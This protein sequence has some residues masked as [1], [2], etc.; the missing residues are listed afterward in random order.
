[1]NT[2][3]RSLV[4][5]FLTLLFAIL[6]AS[7]V[8]VADIVSVEFEDMPK[9]TYLIGEAYEPFTVIV[10]VGEEEPYTLSS[11]DGNVEVTGFNSDTVG[12]RTM[13]I[14]ITDLEDA[15]VNFVYTVV[16]SM[17]DTL[18]AGGS[19]TLEDPY[20]IE[21]AQ[22]LSNVRLALDQN[23]ILNNDIDLS[24]IEWAPIGSVSILT[25]GPQAISISIN[26]GFSGTFDGNDYTIS[27][28]YSRNESTSLP[29]ALFVAVYGAD[30]N[31]K[32]VIKDLT[33]ADV[34]IDSA[35]SVA[36]VAYYA[37][38]VHFQNITVSGT[39]RG[40]GVAGIANIVQGTHSIFEN[41]TNNADLISDSIG[42]ETVDYSFIG[43]IIGQTSLPVDGVVEI[44]NATNNGDFTHLYVESGSGTIAGQILAQ[45]TTGNNGTTIIR[46]P[47]GTG[48]VTGNAHSGT[49]YFYGIKYLSATEL[50]ESMDHFP[51]ADF[52]AQQRPF[53]GSNH[54]SPRTN[55][56]ITWD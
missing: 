12:T 10:T 4:T 53:F 18:F 11:D 17:T 52:T 1:M 7:C 41:V 8:E 39:I 5:V 14:T 3:H 38:D 50:S 13:T 2:R 30:E 27:N 51:Y 36:G 42:S 44:N 22:Q 33:L 6:V 19:G 32:A 47:V 24:E 26:E 20:Q 34:D 46:N 28:L 23:Y 15:S 43:G 48:T 35:F 45:A 21:T 31:N 56:Q 40:R 49:F 25:V 29:V 55:L 37:V 16:N 9:T 54:L